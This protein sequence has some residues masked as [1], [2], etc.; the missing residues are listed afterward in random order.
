MKRERK[1]QIA[2]VLVLMGALTMLAAKRGG[3]RPAAMVRPA[4]QEL[5]QDTIYRMMDAARD[6]N[7][8]A[9]L[10]C[11]TGSM[12][13]SLRQIAKEKGSS[14]LSDY[15]RN[16]NAA[17]KGV[18]IQ[19]PQPGADNELR[20]RVEF[21]YADRNEAQIYYLRQASGSWRIEHQE[22]SQGVPAAVPYGTPV[23]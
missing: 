17:V 9:Y 23:E 12:E 10:A 14:A 2:T 11:F 13:N 18:A 6:G 20:V 16:F 1:A 22:N 15:I 5:P 7:A 8:S 4:A 3:W 19:E 21:V